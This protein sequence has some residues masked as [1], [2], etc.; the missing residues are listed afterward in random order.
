MGARDGRAR[1][2]PRLGLLLAAHRIRAPLP[3]S[4]RS[5]GEELV[6]P[7]RTPG[8][9]GSVRRSGR[10]GPDAPGGGS[11]VPVEFEAVLA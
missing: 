11:G 6:S 1:G 2:T 4:W 5:R 7:A 8:A 10:T 9:R 3:P